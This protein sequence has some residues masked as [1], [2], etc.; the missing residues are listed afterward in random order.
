[1]KLQFV[2]VNPL[3]HVD[4]AAV[5]EHDLFAVIIIK[6]VEESAIKVLLRLLLK[7]IVRS[8][9]LELHALSHLKF[10]VV[11]LPRFLVRPKESNLVLHVVRRQALNLLDIFV[12]L[13][14]H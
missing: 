12:R 14:K 9:D 7:P 1:M 11:F 13:A 4:F 6:L 2:E 10:G 8:V 5:R 3:V